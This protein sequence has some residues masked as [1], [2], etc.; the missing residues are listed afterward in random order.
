MQRTVVVRVDRMH[1]H[2]KYLKYQKRSSKFQAEN[3]DSKY[4]IGDEVVIEETRPLSKEKRWRVSA[5][6]KRAAETRENAEA[7]S[8]ATGQETEESHD[9]ELS[10]S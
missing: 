10:Q 7:E 1:R 3:T 2:P 4:R 5:L 9:K 8:E 6:V